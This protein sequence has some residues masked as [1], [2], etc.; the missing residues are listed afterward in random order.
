MLVMGACGFAA[1]GDVPVVELRQEKGDTLKENMITA[2]RYLVVGEDTK[3]DA[4]AE[5][6]GWKMER[7]EG[8]TRMMVTTPGHGE[9]I[10]RE[11]TVN[12]RYTMEALSGRKI[13]GERTSSVVAGH[14]DPMRGIDQAIRHMRRG[15]KA[16]L[17]LPS[18]QAYGVV[19]DG[20][21]IG[22]REILVV[23]MEV[24]SEK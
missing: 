9:L 11:D 4:Y 14:G 7:L 13:Y 20:G 8:G 2:N 6:H 10:A 12:I 15:A 23:E 3:I 24:I 17:I 5:R 1:C 19:G 16:R 22:H 21:A 18:E